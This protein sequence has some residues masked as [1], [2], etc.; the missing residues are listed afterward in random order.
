MSDLSIIIDPGGIQGIRPGIN[1]QVF[2]QD[3]P[4]DPQNRGTDA[5]RLANSNLTTGGLGTLFDISWTS[6]LS[7]SLYYPMSG[8]LNYTKQARVNGEPWEVVIYQLVEPFVEE[9][10][11]RT[12]YK[13]PNTDVISEEVIDATT[14]LKRWVYWIALQGALEVQTQ[15]T[16]SC[17]KCT[18]NFKEGT[19]LTASME[20]T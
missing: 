17:F 2:P 15:R 6:T 13:V 11:N 19:L 7:E 16:G 20:A 8:L 1:I 18:F 14:G 5:D 3:T 10:V 12:R 4:M 9:S